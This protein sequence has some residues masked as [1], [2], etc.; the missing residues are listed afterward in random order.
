MINRKYIENLFKPNKFVAVKDLITTDRSFEELDIQF[1]R[2]ADT[3]FNN[4]G[5]MLFEYVDEIATRKFVSDNFNRITQLFFAF[6]KYGIEAAYFQRDLVIEKRV[7]LEG[8]ARAY[9]VGGEELEK[10]NTNTNRL[11]M[12]QNAWSLHLDRCYKY[13]YKSDAY[14]ELCKIKAITYLTNPSLAGE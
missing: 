11:S 13:G 1:A 4:L 12:Y 10:Q 6:A 14:S 3:E 9:Q 5:G 8:M 7:L 2:M